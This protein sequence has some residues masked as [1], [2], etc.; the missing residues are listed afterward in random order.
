MP[1]ATAPTCR[2]LAGLL[3]LAGAV[4]VTI[5][6]SFSGA[7]PDMSVAP[8]QRSLPDGTAAATE[9][10]SAGSPSRTRADSGNA[11]SHA[12]AAAALPAS[13]VS[14]SGRVST[15]A[16]GQLVGATLIAWPPARSGSEWASTQRFATDRDGRFSGTLNKAVYRYEQVDVDVHDGTGIVFRGL[17]RTGDDIV[18]LVDAS[19]GSA[20]ML[21]G[22]IVLPQA[23][24]DDKWIAFLYDA[25]G[26]P[27][28]NSGVNGPSSGKSADV[29]LR[30]APWDRDRDGEVT[31]AAFLTTGRNRRGTIGVRREP[32]PAASV[33]VQGYQVDR[34]AA[35]LRRSGTT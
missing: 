25:E 32:R 16:G 24:S 15:M 4:A 6:L 31:L 22:R 18:I 2:A 34:L 17:V 13:A 28:A 7:R 20:G 35:P 19:P 23:R 26:K 8:G 27:L 14:F 10:S 9:R 21:S 12:G 5:V 11:V 1:D 33:L 30:L 29:I 3:L